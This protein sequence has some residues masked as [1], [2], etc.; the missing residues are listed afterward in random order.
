MKCRYEE[1][2]DNPLQPANCKLTGGVCG[3][4]N[5]GDYTFCKKITELEDGYFGLL[6][7]L[8][9][10]TTTKDEVR[11]FIKQFVEVY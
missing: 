6:E 4:C 1:E 11:T 9:Y 5:H 10:P 7:L 2:C 3:I 8:E